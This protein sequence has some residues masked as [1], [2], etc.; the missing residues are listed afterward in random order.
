MEEAHEQMAGATA[1]VAHLRAGRPGE[2]CMEGQR[3]HAGPCRHRGVELRPA[4]GVLRHPLEERG[5]VGREE[6]MGFGGHGREERDRPGHLGG[7]GELDPGGLEIEPIR[8][9]EIILQV[10]NELPKID[11]GYSVKPDFNDMPTEEDQLLVFGNGDLLHT[12]IKNI[13]LNACKYSSSHQAAIS[14]RVKPGEIVIEVV[15]DG[16]GIPEDE[17]EY[18]FQPFYRTASANTQQGFGLGLS[19]AN[20]II[21]LH[22]GFIYVKS[23]RQSNTTFIIILPSSSK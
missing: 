14:L 7:T 21:K 8:I 4:I 9:D 22:K 12:A 13:A 3:M 17:L 19:L 11:P 15:D 23:A 1:N 20:Q 18:I 10:M 5:T 16:P 6:G 2:C